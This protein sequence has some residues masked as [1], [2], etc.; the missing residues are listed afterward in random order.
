M[1]VP[2]T[3]W[4]YE[5]IQETDSITSPITEN[6]IREKRKFRL[7]AGQTITVPLFWV[8]EYL[9][10]TKEKHQKEKRQIYMCV[11]VPIG[12]YKVEFIVRTLRNSVGRPDLM[13]WSE[14][15]FS[16]SYS[17]DISR[18]FSVYVG[19]DEV[20]LTVTKREN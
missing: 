8:I 4:F 17:V 7:R 9:P 20:L 14:G 2:I 10:K 12:G 3:Y 15:D 18:V 19:C 1:G 13:S 5:A 11:A 6:I 16:A